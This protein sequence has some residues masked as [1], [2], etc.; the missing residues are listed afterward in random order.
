[1]Y[2]AK[3]KTDLCVLFGITIRVPFMDQFQV[4]QRTSFHSYFNGMGTFSLHGLILCVYEDLLFELLCIHTAD[5]G[6]FVLHG[7]IF[8]VS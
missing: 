8:C 3:I 6:T 5:M 2:F 4:S 1:M 7:Q